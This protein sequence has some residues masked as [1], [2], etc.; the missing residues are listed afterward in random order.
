MAF[1]K[2]NAQA[3]KL[4]ALSKAVNLPV[5]DMMYLKWPA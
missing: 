5:R 4:S 2:N 3:E 1:Q